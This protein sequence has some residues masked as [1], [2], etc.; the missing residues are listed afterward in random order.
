MLTCWCEGERWNCWERIKIKSVIRE[1]KTPRG[2]PG[3]IHTLVVLIPADISGRQLE[4]VVGVRGG[5]GVLVLNQL[6][7]Q[8]LA[9]AV[10]RPAGP[11]SHTGEICVAISDT[12]IITHA[13]RSLTAW[14]WEGPT[15]KIINRRRI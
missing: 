4:G 13:A 6:L 2:L 14:R 5:G 9:Q 11:G 8:I 10:R 3:C 15:C 12:H 1:E 7:V